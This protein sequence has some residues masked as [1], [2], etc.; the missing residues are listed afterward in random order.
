MT[1][2][3]KGGS[4][5]DLLD[6]GPG[7]DRLAGGKGGDVFRFADAPEA[8]G[9]DRIKDFRSG[10]DTIELSGEV[11]DALPAGPLDAAMFRAGKEARDGDDHIL[12]D[13]A[14]GALRYDADGSGDGDPVL[15]AILADARRLVHGDIVVG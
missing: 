13:R 14:T 4:G 3:S 9:P 10:P 15:I 8:G 12:Y 1:T 2:A 7:A 5:K 11:Y 6:A